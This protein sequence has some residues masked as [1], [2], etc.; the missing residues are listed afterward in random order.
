MNRPCFNGGACGEGKSP[1]A[2][3]FYETI[4]IDELVKSL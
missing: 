1:G 3:I 4:K 2:D